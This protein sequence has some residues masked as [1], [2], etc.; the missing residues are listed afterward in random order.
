MKT[1]P[2]ALADIAPSLNPAFSPNLH[3][4][5]GKNSHFASDGGTLDTV[6]RVRPGAPIEAPAGSL[7]IGYACDDGYFSGS[8]LMGVLC[9]GRKEL[10][11]AFLHL[12]EHLDPVPDFWGNYK[13]LGRCFIDPDHAISF[14]GERWH[15]EGDRRTC[16][17]CGHEQQQEHWTENVEISRWVNVA[18]EGQAA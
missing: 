5:V 13:R 17:W 7:F 10:R 6:W 3:Q 11:W 1:Y 15:E 2:L 18:R 9:N 4:W 14:I 16:L 8:R 12:A